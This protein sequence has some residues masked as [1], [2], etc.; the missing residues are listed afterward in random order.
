M[1]SILVVPVQV[2]ALVLKESKMVVE[3]TA[4]FSRLPYTTSEVDIHPNNPYI[5]EEIVSKPFQNKNL[6]LAKGIHLHWSLPDALTRGTRGKDKLKTEFRE[7][8]N[9]WLIRKKS[10][11]TRVKEWIVLSDFLHPPGIGQEQTCIAYDPKSGEGVQQPFRHLGEKM[12]FSIYDPDRDYPAYAPLTAIGYGEPTFAAFYPNCHSVFGFFDPLGQEPD[13][14]REII[15]LSYEVIGWYSKPENDFFRKKVNAFIGEEVSEAE[16]WEYIQEE[17]NWKPTEAVSDGSPEAPREM[18]CYAK[19]EFPKDEGGTFSNDPSVKKEAQVAVGMTNAEALSAYIGK[20]STSNDKEKLKREQQIEAI[21]LDSRLGDELDVGPRFNQLRHEN[22]FLAEDGG[23]YWFIEK[24]GDAIIDEDWLIKKGIDPTDA[25]RTIESTNKIWDETRDILRQLNEQ[26]KE[27]DQTGWTKTAQQE[28]LFADWYKYMLCAYPPENAWDSYL[29][30][31]DVKCFIEQKSVPDLRVQEWIRKTQELSLQR[32]QVVIVKKLGEIDEKFTSLMGNTEDV[33]KFQ[34][35]SKARPRFWKPKDPALLV[36]GEAL[37]PSRRFGRD[38]ANEE[39]GKLICG[40]I[41][42]PLEVR[43]IFQPNLQI[44]KAI[45]DSI[46]EAVQQLPDASNTWTSQPWNPLVLEWEVK[47][48]PILNKGNSQ[49]DKL[50]YDPN[51]I[52]RN[53]QLGENKPDVDF[54]RLGGDFGDAAGIYTGTAILTGHATKHLTNALAAFKSRINAVSGGGDDSSLL[55]EVESAIEEVLGEAGEKKHVLSQTLGGF[56]DALLMR[57]GSLQLKIKD[58]LASDE[59]QKFSNDIADLVGDK[60]RRAPLPQNDFNPLRA[61]KMMISKLRVIDSF[62]QAI[63]LNIQSQVTSENLE[64]KGREDEILLRPRLLQAAQVDFRWLSARETQRESDELRY[65]NPICGWLMTNNL[66][67]SLMVFNADG[68]ALGAFAESDGDWKPAPGTTTI[69]LVGLDEPWQMENPFPQVLNAHL[70]KMMRYIKNQNDDDAGFLAQ[71]RKTINSGLE[72]IQPGTFSRRQ[73]IAELVGRP[74][75][76]VRARV[77]LLLKSPPA[78]HQAWDAF[79][80]DMNREIRETSA[81]TQ[82][83]FPIRIGAHNQ[84]NDGVVGYWVE[85][86]WDSNTFRDDVFYSSSADTADT[87]K[88][89]TRSGA[90]PVNQAL[91]LGSPPMILNLLFDP[92]GQVNLSTGI[93]PVKTL[94][95][96][97]HLFTEALDNMEVYF[98][99]SPHLVN[100]NGLRLDLPKVSGHSWSFIRKKGTVDPAEWSE[101][102]VEQN[103]ATSKLFPGERKILEGWLKLVKEDS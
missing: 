27:L 23:L 9:R 31:D 97:P 99:S 82:V 81:F 34:L 86:F 85:N 18:I 38:G 51:F 55:T 20:E 93:L 69:D 11:E 5:S 53:F 68:K 32:I 54:R 76:L 45:L 59:Y 19:V 64:A 4:D 65:N 26:Q 7:V 6:L 67:N 3:A 1:G 13:V 41:E 17:F 24:E 62:G 101:A 74:I 100:P 28:Q 25:K 40:L 58:P 42:S 88:I 36:A 103:T 39:E 78:I 52:V 72:N 44:R 33:P 90:E 75:A 22:G 92:N 14:E 10:G 79:K 8:P 12:P 89:D 71:F 80:V 94:D 15:N 56:N 96:P 66:D 49:Q 70:Y 61:G 21:F 50:G 63:D 47:F 16:V 73:S 60:L 84:L 95:I 98:V 57:K 102:S 91:S 37:E 2:D 48:L 87:A 29:D 46:A 83:H 35:K 30:V 43:D 77:D